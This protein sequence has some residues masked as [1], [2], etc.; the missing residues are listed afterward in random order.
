M[1]YKFCQTSRHP[2]HFPKRES[3]NHFGTRIRDTNCNGTFEEEQERDGNK[4]VY[5]KVKK[6]TCRVL[7]S[8][9]AQCSLI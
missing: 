1:T 4:D 7:L 2:H 6:E 3:R 5:I 9:R 8:A